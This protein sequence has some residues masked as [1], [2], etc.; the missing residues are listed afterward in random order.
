M[1][2]I[3]TLALFKLGR[4]QSEEL[5]QI[6]TS[7]M[8]NGVDSPSLRQLAGLA[9]PIMSEAGPLFEKTLAELQTPLPSKNDAL[10]ILARNFAQQIVDG[11]ISPHNGAGQIWW[12]VS[13]EMDAHDPLLLPFVGAAS[14]LDDLDDRTLEDGHDRK[15]YREE[16]T[17][18][19]VA[20][21]RGLLTPPAPSSANYLAARF[22]NIGFSP[23]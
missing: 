13:N 15:N 19:I 10:M 4:L 8:V 3:L 6:A 17:A 12:R 23:N 22:T 9:S 14:E 16:L 7:W 5:P 1:S 11:T 21:A 2:P 18:S 20:S